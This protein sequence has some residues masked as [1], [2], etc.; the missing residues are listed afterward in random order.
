MNRRVE[1]SESRRET[2]PDELDKLEIA[3]EEGRST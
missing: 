1:L 2:S 3:S